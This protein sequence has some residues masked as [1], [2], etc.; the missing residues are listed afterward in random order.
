[1]TRAH[2]ISANGAATTA[3]ASTTARA[4]SGPSNT[5]AL[6]LVAPIALVSQ[7]IWP[8]HTAKELAKYAGCGVRT[9]KRW[10]SPKGSISLKHFIELLRGEHGD[11]FL[12]A[13]MSDADAAWWRRQK[14]IREL[15]E[16]HRRQAEHEKR[17]RG[18]MS[19]F[20][21]DE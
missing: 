20:A 13:Y 7:Q 17:L 14:T 16:L 9:A 4:T 10:L 12:E 3:I 19:L 11:E 2:P 6:H 5:A 18:I 8:K 21:A 15:G 1:M